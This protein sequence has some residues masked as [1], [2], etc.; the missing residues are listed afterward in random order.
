MILKNIFVAKNIKMYDVIEE[1][2]KI[3]PYHCRGDLFDKCSISF[4]YKH[5]LLK[6]KITILIK[7]DFSYFYALL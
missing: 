2:I 6:L 1:F 3:F 5:N 7:L 4:N